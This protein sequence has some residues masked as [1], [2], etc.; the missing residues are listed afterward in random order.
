MSFPPRFGEHNK[1]IYGRVL[2]RTDKEIAGLK[3]KGII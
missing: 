2:G 3:E 1:E